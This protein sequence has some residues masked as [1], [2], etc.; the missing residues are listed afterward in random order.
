M[1]EAPGVY[2]RNSNA[3]FEVTA[4]FNEPVEGFGLDDIL[5][6]DVTTSNF[7]GMDG[8]TVYTFDVTPSDSSTVQL[9]V[10]TDTGIMDPERQHYYVC[11]DGDVLRAI[12]ALMR[13]ILR[14]PMA[15]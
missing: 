4:T 10:S 3:V 7:M 5:V 14:S 12:A 8:D 1:K 2:F 9:Q 13:L 11:S 6:L 15:R